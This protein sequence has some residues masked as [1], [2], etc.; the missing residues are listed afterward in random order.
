M[1]VATTHVFLGYEA[2]IRRFNLRVPALQRVF[3]TT[4]R[5]VEKH[6]RTPDGTELI[7]LPVQH[8]TGTDSV[9]GQLT[10]AFKRE[11]L[12]LTVLGALFERE[13]ALGLSLIHI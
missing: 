7:E 10:F 2:L 4:E 13:E 11:H 12:N 9:V 8:L 5:T 1:A 3:R 6:T